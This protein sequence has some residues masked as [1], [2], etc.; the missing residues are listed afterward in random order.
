MDDRLSREKDVFQG[1]STSINNGQPSR[2][3]SVRAGDKIFGV[4]I[5]QISQSC[6]AQPRHGSI[7]VSALNRS[8]VGSSRRAKATAASASSTSSSASAPTPHGEQIGN[9]GCRHEWPKHA[10]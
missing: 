2:R 8:I 1:H 3:R 10:L 7:C 4:W 9:R 6:G 5:I